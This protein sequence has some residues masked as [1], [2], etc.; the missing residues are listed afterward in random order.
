MTTDISNLWSSDM[1][2][3][4]LYCKLSTKS[5]KVQLKTKFLVHNP[6]NQN[7]DEFDKDSINEPSQIVISNDEEFNIFSQ[8]TIIEPTSQ[9]VISIDILNQNNNEFSKDT[10][11]EPISQT[12]VSNDNFDIFSKDTIDE[13]ISQTVISTDIY[14]E[15]NISAKSDQKQS[16]EELVENINMLI[17][18][19]TVI[20]DLS[21]IMTVLKKKL[22][23]GR[24]V[25]LTRDMPGGGKT[26]LATKL[27]ELFVFFGI[28]ALYTDQD[29]AGKN[30]FI[31]KVQEA[32]KKGILPILGRKHTEKNDSYIY[33]KALERDVKAC[34]LQM[35]KPEDS[36]QRAIIGIRERDF[37]RKLDPSSTHS[38]LTFLNQEQETIYNIL[39]DIHECYI[40]DRCFTDPNRWGA[41]I[42]LPVLDKQLTDLCQ[43][44]F[45]ENIK[46]ALKNLLPLQLLTALL[47]MINDSSWG[48]PSQQEVLYYSFVPKI[49]KDFHQTVNLLLNELAS[50]NDKIKNMMD[51]GKTPDALHV[52]IFYGGY[53]HDI[54]MKLKHSCKICIKEIEILDVGIRFNLDLPEE[55]MEIYKNTSNPHITLIHTG[56]PVDVGKIQR[57]ESNCIQLSTPIE[58]DGVL[59]TK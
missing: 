22:A 31:S 13:P 36:L 38:T 12:I 16:I 6:L 7:D 42:V 11:D 21:E 45:D 15:V 35:G 23:T 18:D 20:K 34:V 37:Q 55:L 4:N 49:P 54:H 40:K 46:V 10:I 53:D 57:N 48:M 43:D 1:F 27:V 28:D 9:T 3:D 8:D 47:G 58:I 56:S 52:T 26:Y 14:E 30:G 19:R 32:I 29:Q 50:K 39:K 17:Q 41:I 24:H 2:I 5:E 59:V 44:V 51:I 33:K 25:I